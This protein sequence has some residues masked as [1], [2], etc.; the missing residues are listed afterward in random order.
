MDRLKEGQ[1]DGPTDGRM[2]GRIEGRTD[3]QTI[4]YRTLPTNAWGPVKD[5][6]IRDVMILFEQEKEDYYEPN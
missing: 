2:K 6:I 5:N 1:K 3:G 4:F